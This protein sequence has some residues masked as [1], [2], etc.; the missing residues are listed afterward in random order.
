M[1][2]AVRDPPPLWC[3]SWC[4]GWRLAVVFTWL[5]AVGKEVEKCG[6]LL[7]EKVVKM[8]WDGNLWRLVAVLKKVVKYFG[9]PPFVISKYATDPNTKAVGGS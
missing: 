2:E 6:K 4:G 1:Q 9:R 5:L 3:D 8:F 7:K